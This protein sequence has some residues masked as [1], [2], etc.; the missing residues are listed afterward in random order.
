VLVVR[1][2]SEPW[3]DDRA[4]ASARGVAAP[5][6]APVEEEPAGA[7]AGWDAGGAVV[8]DAGCDAPGADAPLVAGAVGD[9]AALV[10]ALG[11]GAVELGVGGALDGGALECVRLGLLDGVDGAWLVGAVEVVGAVEADGAW[12]WRTRSAGWS[13]PLRPRKK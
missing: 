8:W 5:P 9:V 1:G 4:G 12:V 13:A 6:A 11:V 3:L 7:D 2:R 10:G